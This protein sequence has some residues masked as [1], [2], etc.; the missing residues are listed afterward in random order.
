MVEP[1][2]AI[3]NFLKPTIGSGPPP[4]GS[5]IVKE[6]GEYIVMEGSTSDYMIIE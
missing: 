1:M 3:G 4:G 6:T 5:Y 2:N